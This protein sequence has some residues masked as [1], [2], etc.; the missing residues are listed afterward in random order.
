MN[1]THRTL[2]D[3]RLHAIRQQER[4]RFALLACGALTL[5]LALLLLPSLAFA[6]AAAAPAETITGNKFADLLF[7]P[8]GLGIIASVVG[9]VMGA[10]KIN[11]S[12]WKR[13]I[14]TAAYHAFHIVE[15]V[16][17]ED[18]SENGIDK[19]ARGL[20]A[21]DDFFKANGWREARPEEKALAQLYFQSQN[22]AHQAAEKVA[23]N[24]VTNALQAAG[25]VPAAPGAP[26]APSP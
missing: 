13:R 15:D 22:G 18:P 25:L 5:L 16:A 17:A 10:F 11:D 19:V 9:V 12:T 1:E 20:K 4:R 2:F 8:G 7:S 21:F 23:T 24:A 26:A 6:Q 3:K 14:G